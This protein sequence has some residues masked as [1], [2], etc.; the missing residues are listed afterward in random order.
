MLR[1]KSVATQTASNGNK[2]KLMVKGG[3]VR[4]PRPEKS[5]IFA[6]NLALKAPEKDLIYSWEHTLLRFSMISNIRVIKAS[7]L[8]ILFNPVARNNLLFNFFSNIFYICEFYLW[9]HHL[10]IRH[11]YS[12]LVIMSQVILVDSCTEHFTGL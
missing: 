11:H 3:T 5:Y 2:S 12:I 1:R 10:K 9:P 8:F 7:R 4:E 6:Y